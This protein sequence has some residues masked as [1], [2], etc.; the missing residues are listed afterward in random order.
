[1]SFV[2]LHIHS[3]YSLLEGLPKIDD[4]VEAAKKFEMPALALTDY[5]SLYGAIEFYKRAKRAKIKPIIGLE[6]F[7]APGG[8]FSKPTLKDEPH[9][10]VLL[11]KDENGYKNLMKLSSLGHLEGFWHGKPRVDKELL[12]KH[13]EGL[14]AL[15]G[16]LKGEI[17]QTIVKQSHHGRAKALAEE[18][19]QIFGP[20]NFYLEL[21]DH[22]ELPG[23]LEANNALISISKEAA[24]P[25]VVTQDVHYL[26]LDDREAQEVLT[27]VGR[28]EK[29]AN[30]NRETY[31]FVDRS[32]SDGAQIASRFAHVPEA[33]AN[34]LKIAEACNLEL[35]LGKWHFPAI[36]LPPSQTPEDNLKEQAQAGLANFFPEG[37]SEEV[38]KRL[39]YELDIIINKGYAPYFL[40]VTDFVNWARSQKIMATTRGSAAGSLVSYLLGITTVNPLDFKLPFE[41]FL[42]PLRPSPPDIDMDFADN[43]RDEVI[44][45]VTKKYGADRVAQIITFGTMA[46][47]ASV[48]DVGRAL[49]YSYTF[50]DQVAKM[51]PFGSQGFPMTLERALEITPE[52]KNLYETNEQIKRLLDLARKIEGCARHTS[53]HAAGVVISPLPLTEFTPIQRETGSDKITT[54]YDMNSVEEAGLLKMDFLGVRNLSI[55]GEA[56]KLVEKTRGVSVDLLNLPFDDKKTY[57]MLARGETGGVFQLNGAGM[58]RHLVELKPTSIFDIMAMVA[59]FRPGPMETIPE[60]IRRKHNPKLIKYLDSRMKDYLDMSYGVLTYQDDVLLTAINL[61]GYTWSEADKLRKAMGK[62]IPAEMAA[63]EEKFISGCLKNGVKPAVARE[64]W[65]QIEPFAAYGFNKSHGASYAIVAYQTAYM[66]AHFPA[67]YMAAVMSAES[68]DIDKVAEAVKDCR[69]IGLKV[70]PPDI[71]ESFANFAVVPAEESAA[72]NT[73]RFGLTAIKNVGAHLVDKII[74]ERQTGGPFANLEDFLSR[75]Q[76]KDLN[77]KSLESLIK[78]GALD[79]FGERGELLANLDRLLNFVKETQAAKFSQQVSLFGSGPANAARLALQ[80]AVQATKNERLSWEK[81]LIGLY[82]SEHPFAQFQNL[83]QPEFLSIN[84]LLNQS[85]FASE[86]LLATGGL[87]AACKRILTKKGEHMAFVD[88]EDTTGKIEAVVFSRVFEK[89]KELLTPGALI[90]LSGRLSSR[91]GEKKIIA[92]KAAALNMENIQALKKSFGQ[93]GGQK[94]QEGAAVSSEARDPLLVP[95]RGGVRVLQIK[96]TRPPSK[97]LVNNLRSLLLSHSGEA[98]VYLLVQTAGGVK[99][100]ATELKVR[101]SNE[102][103]QAIENLVGPGSV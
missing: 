37:V 51:I 94:I 18:Y 4:L 35:L 88:L 3:H 67:E 77:K 5:G 64:L 91:E 79:R 63:Q 93:I 73:I 47:R 45:Y 78:C 46:A 44:D 65:H 86:A 68:G 96:I 40:V 100:L 26:S 22:P 75:V 61:A 48:R 57:E 19:Q 95:G 32:F 103:K 87:V 82:V 20:G 53:V 36:D 6:V 25:L 31:N 9:H 76:D 23:Q 17:S 90:C 7:V 34:T 72:S 71:N 102:L 92:E 14:I 39:D 55:L 101:L 98:P 83:L 52:L 21:Q 41:R 38:R 99:K 28:G 12:L 29:L 70:L 15:S 10:L 62:K 84:D 43:R 66:K 97:E 81:E 74:E 89:Y 54:Q 24:I 69:D 42:N 11:A 80:P 16:C 58:T 56:A 49:G 50:C 13:H 1:M 8:H 85:A 33:V 59:L 27:C 60:F 2:H 30:P